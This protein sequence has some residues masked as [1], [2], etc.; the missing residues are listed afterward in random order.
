MD[1]PVISLV[2]PVYNQC[3]FIVETIESVLS[4]NIAGLEYIVVDDG[5]TDEIDRAVEPYLADIRYIKKSNSGQSSTLNYA[6]SLCE[7]EYIGYL[8]ADDKFSR[9]DALKLM[10]EF[11]DSTGNDIV[12]PDYRLIDE[13]GNHLRDITVKEFFKEDLVVRLE[14]MIGPGAIFR[15]TI[16]NSGGGW[17]SSFHQSPDFEFWFRCAE[18]EYLFARF[19][20]SLADYRVHSGSGMVRPVSGDRADEILRIVNRSNKL[21][22]N[23]K[24]QRT[25]HASALLISCRSHGQS[26]RGRVCVS[27]YIKACFLDPGVGFSVTGLRM[28][29][30]GLVRVKILRLFRVIK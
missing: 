12:Y 29:I 15:K 23:A 5:S 6:W 16:F 20:E 14:C 24:Q 22:L 1:T 27:R 19:G 30:A 10:V 21:N 28:L 9:N 2:T 26:G 25:Q 8:S 17:D 18:R 7:G 4:Q 13:C 3:E 11:A